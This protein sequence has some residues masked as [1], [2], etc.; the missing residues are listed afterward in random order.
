MIAP[1]A[2]AMNHSAAY[3]LSGVIGMLA[4]AS[5]LVATYITGVDVIYVAAI[6]AVL[7]FA[8]TQSMRVL[9]AKADRDQRRRSMRQSMHMELDDTLD[10]LN[11][12]KYE[13]DAVS[14]TTE[15]GTRVYFMTRYLNH[16]MYDSALYS[17]GISL[18]RM[19]SRQGLQNTYRL[20]KTH[21]GLLNQMTEIS[22]RK[23]E[24]YPKEAD[25]IYVALDAIERRL[26]KYIPDI[27][28]GL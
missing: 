25:R 19:E 2:T 21:N 3:G 6:I 9:V 24:M 20:I 5:A 14:L 18:V 13:N 4:V 11:R 27:K 12:E 7:A 17:G 26:L 8:V 23:G 10:A 22:I 28:K 1:M 15:E 16:D